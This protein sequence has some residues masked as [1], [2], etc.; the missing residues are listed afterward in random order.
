M[1]RSADAVLLDLLS[2]LPTGWAWTRRSDKVLPSLLRVL[3]AAISTVEAEADLLMIEIDPSRATKLLS[4]FERVLGPDPCGLDDVG[5]PI[6][7]RRLQAWRRWTW[8]GGSSRAWFLA[9]AAKYGIEIEIEEYRPTVCGDEFGAAPLICSPEQF[10]WTVKLSPLWERPPIF[11][12]QV[13]GDYFGEVGLSPI[14][15]VIRRF[16][17]AHTVVVFDYSGV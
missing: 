12:D 2:L 17:P 1:S 8:K 14:E 4:A 6:G 16:A 7:V 10:V 3:A 5:G 15:C 9:L 13:C 11:G